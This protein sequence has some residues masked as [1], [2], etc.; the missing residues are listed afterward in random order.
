ML[1]NIWSADPRRI[2]KID[3]EVIYPESLAIDRRKI[4]TFLKE[5]ATTAR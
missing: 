4:G 1:K 5:L 2:G 3:V